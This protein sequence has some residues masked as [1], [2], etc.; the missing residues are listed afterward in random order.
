MK[1]LS[2]GISRLNEFF[3]GF[4]SLLN[5]VLILAV[6]ID[7]FQRYA[8]KQSSATF[9]EVE[10]HLFSMIFLLGSGWTLLHDRHV[11]VDIF[12]SNWS[13]KRQSFI[14]IFGIIFFLFPFCIALIFSA[15]PYTMSAFASNESSP[16]TGGLPY[17]WVVKSMMI[18]CAA[19]TLLQGIAKII[20]LISSLASK[21]ERLGS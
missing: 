19:L 12:Y 11:R 14:N 16:D 9:Y 8:L 4:A 15:V 18:F 17:R 2:R 13:M 5:I 21:E 6:A 1:G 10:W 20:E 7:V 3:G